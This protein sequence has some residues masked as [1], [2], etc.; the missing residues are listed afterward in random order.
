MDE[1][2]IVA[3]SGSMEGLHPNLISKAAGVLQALG[4]T[5]SFSAHCMDKKRGD[6]VDVGKRVADLHDAFMD[7]R[8]AVVLIGVGGTNAIDMLPHIDYELIR[9]H[10]KPICGFS[11]STVILNAIYARTGLITYY[12]PMLFSFAGNVEPDYTIEYFRKAVLQREPYVLTPAAKWGNYTELNSD[13]L[14]DGYQWIREGNADGL[15]VGGHVP[16]LNLLQGTE[17]LPDLNG[18]VVFIEICERYGKATIDKL[19]QY[20]GAL[21][22]QKGAGGI[23]ALLVGRLFGADGVTTDELKRVLLA[24]EELSHIPIII[25]VDF[26]HTT[27]MV[28]LPVG[29]RI[30]VGGDGIFIDRPVG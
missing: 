19:N 15:L 20:L 22:L 27:P 21:L 30:R 25:N 7:P 10:P 29:G 17:Y 12:G 11:D 28:T 26:G 6:A 4:L 16:S 1:I 14:N 3:V 9:A 2:R 8:V 5:V 23:R 13:K 18:A 24:R